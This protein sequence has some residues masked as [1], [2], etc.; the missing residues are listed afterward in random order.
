M[1]E[2][3]ELKRKRNTEEEEPTIGKLQQEIQ[4]M[5]YILRDVCAKLDKLEKTITPIS[6]KAVKLATKDADEE[7]RKKEEI[8][9]FVSEN[10]EF[11]N[12]FSDS[13]SWNLVRGLFKKFTKSFTL[14]LPKLK[15]GEEL[16]SR[17]Q[18]IRIESAR[19]Y[20]IKQKLR[21]PRL[22]PY[23][24]LVLCSKERKLIEEEESEVVFR[25]LMNE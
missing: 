10:I 13:V 12:N 22:T 16:K 25:L 5:S 23:E 7:I 11:T 21:I 17:S 6:Q 1:T 3:E 24:D 14:P 4:M 9:N 19:V 18:L 8:T 15:I 20:G 2:H